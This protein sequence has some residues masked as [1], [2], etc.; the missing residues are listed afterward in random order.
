[1]PLSASAPHLN[2]L[3]RTYRSYFWRRLAFSAEICLVCV[4]SHSSGAPLFMAGSATG[5]VGEL[6]SGFMK[7][8]SQKQR[9]LALEFAAELLKG[10]GW[11][12]TK[13][14][15]QW[16]DDAE[17]HPARFQSSLPALQILALLGFED[18]LV[19]AREFA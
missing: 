3:R 15:Q 11:V 18:E 4:Q 14:V 9:E 7:I 19:L 2:A 5:P 17:L 16:I 8:I 13:T 12:Q 10:D 6:S 1:V